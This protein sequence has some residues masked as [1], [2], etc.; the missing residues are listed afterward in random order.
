MVPFGGW[1]MPVRYASDLAEHHAVREAA[2]LFDVSHMGRIELTGADTV[3][4]LEGVLVSRVHDLDV[5]RARY[6]MLCDEQG[7]V[8]DDLIVTRLDGPCT[9]IVA[10]AANTPQVLE[11]LR[12]A[13]VGGRDVTLT[14]REG[15]VLLALQGPSAAAVLDAASSEDRATGEP[16]ASA[17]RPFR[18]TPTRIAGV[19]GDRVAHRLHRRGRV[20][21]RLHG[22][23]RRPGSGTRCSPPAPRTGS[24]PAAS[25]HG[26][27]SGSRRGCRCTGTSWTGARTVRGRLRAGRAPRRGPRL[28]GPHGPRADVVARA[29][30]PRRR[31][32]RRGPSRTAPGYPVL[33]GEHG[34]QRSRPGRPPRRSGRRS[35]SPRS[36]RRTLGARHAAQVDVRGTPSRHASSLYPSSHRTPAIRARPTDR[37][38]C[39]DV[40]TDRSYT[41]EHEWLDAADPA[42]VGITRHAADALGDVVYVDL[43]RGRSHRRR[44]RGVRRDRVD[45]VG[46]RPLRARRRRDRGG[47]RRRSRTIRALVNRDPYGAGWLVRIRV[48]EVWTD[49]YRRPPDEHRRPSAYRALIG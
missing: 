3:D 11:V 21:D 2:G 18:A 47:Q 36:S 10:N 16:Q 46:Q 12:G 39:M 20:R 33:D 6:T 27:R 7:G 9:S 37:S 45:E 38:R 35:P 26:T 29:G 49:A 1:D 23:R 28:P 48:T 4:V 13:A 5:G 41:A 25:P 15:H 32:R 14:H 19:A 43:P 22:R 30:T 40:P 44:W 17:L 34:R 8:I 42:T 31:T 24:S